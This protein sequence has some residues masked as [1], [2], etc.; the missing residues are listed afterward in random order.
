M[1]QPLR[2]GLYS[3]FFGSTIGGGE[4]YLGVTAEAIRDAFPQHQLE[5]LS[6]V[7]ADQEL[8]QR[9]LK[10]DLSGI[11]FRSTNRRVTRLHKFLN[12]IP[13]AR[14]YRDLFLS[15]Q[16]VKFTAQYDL[17][18]A[19]VYVLP[20]FT[21][22]RRSVMLCQFPYEI[23]PVPS[24]HK[25][26]SALAYSVYGFPNRVLRPIM[27]GDDL[28]NFDP[29]VCQS[30]YVRFWVSRYWDRQAEVVN[31]P[32]DVPEEP[33]D[34]SRKRNVILGVGR[35]FSVGHSK[36]QD[37]M[38]QV[39][40]RM[41]DQGLTGWELHL[42]GSVHRE[43]HNVG[44]FEGIKTDSVGYPIHLHPDASYETVQNLYAQASVYWH[45]AGY[46]VDVETDPINLEHFGMTTAEAMG[47]GVVPVVLARGG[48]TEVV[49]DGSDGLLW[50]DL[51]ELR[52]K[53]QS[54]IDDS[55]L[56][57][58]LGEAAYRS[59]GRFSRSQFKAKMTAVLAPVV[60]DLERHPPRDATQARG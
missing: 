12:N 22:A 29:I 11:T 45:A 21:R 50:E 48:Q 24:R 40:K 60:A 3:P 55:H 46:G 19:M 39:F 1:G 58:R 33:P 26:L 35:F 59:A 53:T 31:P 30:E 6:P 28:E 41:C 9:M 49:S 5:I 25:G 54:L 52:T 51:D 42:A 37:L 56:R 38:V 36:R 8:Y 34:W 17:F 13:A 18:I 20:A 2:I 16:A 27:V 43:S 4:K 15:A 47:S 57:R 7:P 14:M 44:F 10:L 32:I 23:G